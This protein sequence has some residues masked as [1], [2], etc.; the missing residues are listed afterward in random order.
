MRVFAGGL[1]SCGSGRPTYLVTEGAGQFDHRGALR[2]ESGFGGDEWDATLMT[3]PAPNTEPPPMPN[4]TG[5]QVARATY[6]A[7]NG[8]RPVPFL[9]TGL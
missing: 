9:E 6:C 2:V 8:T 5:G 1:T 3:V 4:G 7:V